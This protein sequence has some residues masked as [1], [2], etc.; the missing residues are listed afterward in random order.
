MKSQSDF[1]YALQQLSIRPAR[2]NDRVRSDIWK[3]LIT[4]N[5][6]DPENFKYFNWALGQAGNE[7]ADRVAKEG[8]L[9]YQLQVS[10]DLKS[11]ITQLCQFTMQSW[12]RNFHQKAQGKLGMRDVATIRLPQ[13]W[14]KI[15][16][17]R[18]R[19][20]ST[21]WQW[22]SSYQA[23]VG[24]CATTICLHCAMNDET[25]KCLLL[26]CPAERQH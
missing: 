9:I 26:S 12:C 5:A 14:L 15:C 22:T 17:G 24:H 10:K 11:A 16:H 1:R 2:Q 20:L 18:N 7:M 21:N 25:A 13:I 3:N 23:S 6:K 4:V 8:T 19:E